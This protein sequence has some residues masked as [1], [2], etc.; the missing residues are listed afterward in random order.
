MK[1][2]A[3][4]LAMLLVISSC[5]SNGGNYYVKYYHASLAPVPQGAN[6]GLVAFKWNNNFKL[7]LIGEMMKKGYKVKD[8]TF[9][10]SLIAPLSAKELKRVLPNTQV[11][12]GIKTELN[13]F[14]GFL[15]SKIYSN[16]TF[17]LE[18]EEEVRKVFDVLKK[19]YKI[20]YVLFLW[21]KTKAPSS[22]KEGSAYGNIEWY[23]IDLDT[24]T[25]VGYQKIKIRAPG[26]IRFSHLKRVIDKMILPT[27]AGNPIRNPKLRFKGLQVELQKY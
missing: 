22:L 9:I 27:L 13:D 19:N 18:Y 3:L 23:L 10:E 26:T 12:I 25:A 14:K 5:A 24:F 17:S 6:I 20:R 15:R 11:K 1:K 8:I 2:I 4:V 16:G 7:L 21:E